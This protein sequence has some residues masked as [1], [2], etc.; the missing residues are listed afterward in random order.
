MTTVV[1]S[2]DESDIK[3]SLEEFLEC[4]QNAEGD[5]DESK[6]FDINRSDVIYSADAPLSISEIIGF[7]VVKESI[8]QLARQDLLD[9]K[10][11]L[12]TELEEMVEREKKIKTGIKNI[13]D[14][15]KILA[16]GGKL[17]GDALKQLKSRPFNIYI[18]PINFP[19]MKTTFELSVTMGTTVS[20][21]TGSIADRLISGLPDLK[22]AQMQEKEK[23]KFITSLRLVSDAVPFESAYGRKTIGQLGVSP[24]LTVSVMSRLKGGGK[25]SQNMKKDAEAKKKVKKD[26]LLKVWKGIQEKPVQIE[27][28]KDL[29]F[30]IK[31]NETATKLMTYNNAPMDGVKWLVSNCSL[32]LLKKIEKLFDPENSEQ[33]NTNDKDTRLKKIALYIFNEEFQKVVGF[34]DGLED[35]ID[36]CVTLF[37]YIFNK[38]CLEATTSKFGMVQF[39]TMLG[40]CIA[41]KEGKGEKDDDEMSALM[42]TLKV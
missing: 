11:E 30:V 10:E 42:N 14:V 13:K 37:G 35:V 24:N 39:Q 17:K 34:K 36:K 28:Y 2:A 9:M 31:L 41:Y 38:A 22:R 6:D 7:A 26:E 27:N 8:E 1:P 5:D 12:E 23:K 33:F 3:V 15:L 25:S 18:K 32:E 29:P 19:W 20:S 21:L 40:K 16:N 4:L